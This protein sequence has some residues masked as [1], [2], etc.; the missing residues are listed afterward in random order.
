M[1][2]ERILSIILFSILHWIL[3]I[4]MLKDLSSR[5][6]VIGG[7]KAPWAIVII[8]LVF[9]GSVLYLVFHPRVLLED[10]D[11]QNHL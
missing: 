4:M 1:E 8:V 7:R 6:K 5:E 2:L 10:D 11:K 3:A 9:V